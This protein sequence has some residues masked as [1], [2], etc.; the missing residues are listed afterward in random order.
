MNR[1]ILELSRSAFIH[2]SSLIIHHS[3]RSCYPLLFE[4]Y[5]PKIVYEINWLM[6]LGP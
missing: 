6:K 1:R 2:H 5:M 4:K 3:T